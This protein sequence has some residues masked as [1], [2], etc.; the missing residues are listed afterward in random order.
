MVAHLGRHVDPLSTSWALC[1]SILALCWPIWADW[2]RTM[3]PAPQKPCNLQPATLRTPNPTKVLPWARFLSPIVKNPVLSSAS[4]RRHLGRTTP[5]TCYAWVSFTT[6]HGLLPGLSRLTPSVRPS[7]FGWHGT[8][9][10]LYFGKATGLRDRSRGK[11]WEAP[12]RGPR[13]NPSKPGST[14]ARR[15]QTAQKRS[16]PGAGKRGKGASDRQGKALAELW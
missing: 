14:A 3:T 12:K 11:A 5:L 8:A 13:A 16:R 10:K 9:S 6:T 7:L 4:H 2:R 15:A 1:S